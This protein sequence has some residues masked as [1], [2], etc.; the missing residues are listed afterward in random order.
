MSFISIYDEGRYNRKL[1]KLTNLNTAVYW[2]EL[3]E[4]IE[5]VVR[6]KKF[7]DD[8][9]FKLDRKYMEDQTGIQ[10]DDQLEAESLLEK[11]GVLERNQSDECKLRV[12]L[13]EMTELL[14][15][16]KTQKL[17]TSKT[18]EK[19][20]RA[21]QKANKQACILITMKNILSEADPE[22]RAKYEEWIESVYARG[23]PSGFLTKVK[24]QLFE[25][26]IN[27]FSA[28]KQVKLDLLTE[29]IL[30]GYS[31]ADWVISRY[32]SKKRPAQ[33]ARPAPTATIIAE[34]QKVSTSVDTNIF[35]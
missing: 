31:D 14:A 9:Y 4:I 5:Q 12:Q 19:I 25:D 26:K 17:E 2:S 32:T 1:V 22:L 15:D 21:Q 30:S 11:L 27:S 3:L 34:P 7:D 18:K 16:D 20:S 23:G 10:L 6:K 33:S 8:G 28:D 24:I 29:A 35:F 13:K